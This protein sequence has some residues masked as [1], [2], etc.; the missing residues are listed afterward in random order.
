MTV[1]VLASFGS[2]FE[3]RHQVELLSLR[4]AVPSQDSA[5]MFPMV[6]DDLVVSRMLF[7]RFLMKKMSGVSRSRRD[8]VGSAAIADGRARSD[9]AHGN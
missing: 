4:F 9:L 8:E 6:P 7:R 3:G 2:I 5:A 1:V